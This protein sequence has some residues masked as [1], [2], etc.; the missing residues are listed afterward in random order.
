[1]SWNKYTDW[2]L[3]RVLYCYIPFKQLLQYVS[4]VF[5]HLAIFFIELHVNCYYVSLGNQFGETF[6]H[7][8]YAHIITIV[9]SYS[10]QLN[11]KNCSIL[12]NHITLLEKVIM[13]L[14]VT[15]SSILYFNNIYLTACT[16]NIGKQDCFGIG[17]GV[18]KYPWATSCPWGCQD[19]IHNS[20][21]VE[22]SIDSFPES[23]RFPP[24]HYSYNWQGRMGKPCEYIYSTSLQWY[25]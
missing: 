2:F 17:V 7:L 12:C 20:F 11:A 9:D 5:I 18:C 10:T 15:W 1:M 25:Y 24:S 21:G 16:A 4:N 23:H 14:S 3:K 8:Q 13:Q 19:L 22:R 6:T